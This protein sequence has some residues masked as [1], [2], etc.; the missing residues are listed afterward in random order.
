MLPIESVLDTLLNTVKDCLQ[1]N[2]Q[3][4]VVV[5]APPGAGKT[6]RIPLALLESGISGISGK[7]ILI[8]PRRL[9]V[10]GAARQLAKN[11]NQ[12]VGQTV[13]FRTRYDRN[14]GPNTQIEVVTDGLFLNQIQNDPELNGVSMV[15]FDEFHERSVAMDLALA[16]VLETQDALRDTSNPLHLLVMSAT[17]N[18][19][20]LSAWLNAPLIESQGRSFPVAIHYSPKSTNQYLEQK[21]T[22]QIRFALQQES[23]DILVFLPGMK[24]IK[25]VQQQLNDSTLDSN[26]VVYPLHAT[27]PAD[28]QEK[29]LQPSPSGQRKVVLSTNVAETSI[30]IEGIRI[31]IDSG[32]ARVSRYDER[33]GMNQLITESIAAASAEQRAGRAG[34][35]QPGVCYRIWG[36]SHQA[37]LKPYADPEILTSDLAP[38][39]L[40]MARWGVNNSQTLTLLNQPD[41]ESFKR[42]QQLLQELGA[43]N[44][45]N[46]ITELGKRIASLPLPPRLGALL[47]HNH[48]TD[49]GQDC[50]FLC[51]LLSEGD[52]LSLPH[53]HFQADLDLRLLLQQHNDNRANQAKLKRIKQTSKQLNQSV[54]Q[55]A[56]PN[57]P[58]HEPKT[59]KHL[60]QAL[61]L[62]FPDRIAQ[63]RQPNS[64]RYLMSNGKGVQLLGNDK[65]KNHP[66]LVVLDCDGDKKEPFIRLACPIT[67]AQLK[68]ALEQHIEPVNDIT[69]NNDKQRVDAQHKEQLGAITLLAEPMQAPWPQQRQQQVLTTLLQ[70]IE[71]DQLRCLPWSDTSQQL[72]K[73]L[74]WLHTQ[75]PDLWPSYGQ[76][77]LINDSEQW[78]LPFLAGC[79]RFQDLTALNLPEA[80][81]SRLS[82]EQQS[83]I[84]TLAPYHWP[85]PTGR[86]QTLDYD[87]QQ[88]PV[89]RARMQEF[90]GMDEHPTLP[91]G[92]R[93]TV[94]LLSPAQRPIQITQ[95]LPGFWQGSYK[96][97][98][99]E[100]RG[101]Y[102]KHFWPDNPES[103]Q[104]TTKTKRHLPDG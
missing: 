25:Q 78:L 45:N 67:K 99:K 32:L 13:G 56:A 29:A 84:E 95:D 60:A 71:Q 7:I 34:R 2:R 11:L 81:K 86:H 37:G 35:T 49:L 46:H 22:E 75:Q 94:E 40:E 87:E 17:L 18:G 15:I 100:M 30:T 92:H 3:P 47:L 89:L 74:Q 64:T 66:Y 5:Q 97:V 85:L 26:M 77:N 98:A 76:Q 14:I 19:Q 6:T 101:R 104:A 82:W 9:A 58:K 73:R 62:A 44:Q 70:A 16:F 31:V 57:T 103:A 90:Y 63:Q 68:Q 39:V 83:Q 27:L 36:E 80:L 38:I 12:P 59:K 42:A 55:Q 24:Q 8:Q 10:Y 69:W 23:G 50:L 54:K 88:G 33:R 53:D 51:A 52:P 96:E 72:I 48:T 1:E 43:L 28:Q 20:A 91:N 61:A 79:T 4:R 41:A 21:V 102:P 93:I 65:L